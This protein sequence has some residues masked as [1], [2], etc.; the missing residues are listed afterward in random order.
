ME[1][2]GMREREREREREIENESE[3]F[4]AKERER[5][6]NKNRKTPATLYPAGRA[7]P[8]PIKKGFIGLR[9]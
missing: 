5:E 9:S 3:S 8:L 4:R 7:P 6:M 1:R 2:E